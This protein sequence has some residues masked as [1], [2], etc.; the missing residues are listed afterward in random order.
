MIKFLL[1]RLVNNR[2]SS[3]RCRIKRE[4]KRMELEEK[5][6][7]LM[8]KVVNKTLD[9][10]FRVI[11]SGD[12]LG[13][14]CSYSSQLQIYDAHHKVSQKKKFCHHKIQSNIRSD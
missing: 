6:S 3:Q 13:T 9:D 14:P 2:V 8:V 4:L 10:F 12:L 7:Q 11:R 5:C 1:N